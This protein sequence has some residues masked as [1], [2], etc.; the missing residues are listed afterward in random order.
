MTWSPDTPLDQSPANHRKA[1]CASKC[2]CQSLVFTTLC[3]FMRPYLSHVSLSLFCKSQRLTIIFPDS[4]KKKK[5]FLKQKK[6]SIYV[7]LHPSW[8]GR[9]QQLYYFSADHVTQPVGGKF[10]VLYSTAATLP[11]LGNLKDKSIII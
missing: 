5:R 8:S 11:E 2:S 1:V 3:T 10:P 6:I 4:C 7:H 9:S